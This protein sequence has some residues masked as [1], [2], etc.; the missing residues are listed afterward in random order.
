MAAS[1]IISAFAVILPLLASP[2]LAGSIADIEHVVLFMQGTKLLIWLWDCTY[3][4]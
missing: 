1:N 4:L 2:A 3:N